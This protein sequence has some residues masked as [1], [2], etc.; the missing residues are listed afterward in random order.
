MKANSKTR[1]AV[2]KEFE[3][4]ILYVLDENE[5]F[6]RLF[7]NVEE[8]IHY[9]MTEMDLTIS[10]VK[11]CKFIK[12]VPK[13]VVKDQVEEYHN[14]CDNEEF[15][16]KDLFNGYREDTNMALCVCSINYMVVEEKQY[17]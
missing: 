2:A 14:D 4:R 13:Y 7:S 9:L 8:A 5:I 12:I 1:I 3:D 17:E 11:Q 6:P 15:T 16:S 10:D